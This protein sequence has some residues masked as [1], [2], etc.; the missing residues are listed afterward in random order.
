MQGQGF[1]F[2]VEISICFN[3]VWDS[4]IRREHVQRFRIEMRRLL[5][6]CLHKSQESVGFAASGIPSSEGML[7]NT[8]MKSNTA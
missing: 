8:Q 4:P 1:W 7:S 2:G 3:S 5:E 6:T